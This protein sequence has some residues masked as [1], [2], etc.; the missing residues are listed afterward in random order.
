[1]TVSTSDSA[2]AAATPWYQDLG[3]EWQLTSSISEA[4]RFRGLHTA[5]AHPVGAF[6]RPGWMAARVPGSVHADLIRGGPDR[7]PQLWPAQSG[8][9]VG[10]CAA[11][12]VPPH[13][14]PGTGPITAPAPV[15]RG[16]RSWGRGLP[17]RRVAGVVGGHAYAC[18][19]GHQWA[20][21]RLRASAGGHFARAACRGRS[22]GPHQPD[23]D[24]QAPFRLLV[25]I[26][27][28][29]WCMWGCGAA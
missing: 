5:Q 10:Q 8:R 7:R 3:G 4:W 22:T 27:G 23:A 28:R 16:G 19:P 14:P 9:R 15:F 1:M 6:A 29:G 17:E 13:L 25:G 18:A 26:L 11:V 21:S 12:G 24:A 20:G 2:H